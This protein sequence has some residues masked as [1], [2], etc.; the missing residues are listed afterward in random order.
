MGSMSAGMISVST[1][2]S[3]EGIEPLILVSI[4]SY[5]GSIFDGI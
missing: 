4:I 2:N 1:I 3:G 5:L